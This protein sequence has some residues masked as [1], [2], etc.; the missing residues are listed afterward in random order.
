MSA[1]G[2]NEVN[3]P[4]SDDGG[5]TLP[6]Q[7]SKLA[8][9][10]TGAIAFLVAFAENP[11]GTIQNIVLTVV[12]DYLATAALRTVARILTLFGDAVAQAAQ[13]P[14]LIAE[15]IIGVGS[16]LTAPVLWLLQQLGG[17]TATLAAS[18]GPFGPVVAVVVVAGGLY[19]IVE[20]AAIGVDTVF[21]RGGDFLRWLRGLGR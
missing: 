17:L 16:S 13:A 12:F 21:P 15:G 11:V 3:E 2:R 9:L 10:S 18:A 19:V 20:V 14:I 5:F 6:S 8:S 4:N 7:L 1:R